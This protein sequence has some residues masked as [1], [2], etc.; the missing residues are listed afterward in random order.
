MISRQT[1]GSSCHKTPFAAHAIATSVQRELSSTK[2]NSSSGAAALHTAFQRH[3][4]PFAGQ[5]LHL[6]ATNRSCHAA[7]K[8]HRPNETCSRRVYEKWWCWA[9]S[10]CCFSLASSF[11]VIHSPWAMSIFLLYPLGKSLA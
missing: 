1:Q 9:C 6:L 11:L 8:A 2:S 10:A 4:C 7:S 3:A 5:I